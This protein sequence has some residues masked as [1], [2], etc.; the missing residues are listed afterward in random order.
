MDGLSDERLDEVVAYRTVAGVPQESAI[1]EMLRHVVNHGTYHRGQLATMLRQL[2][3][4]P[5]S[6][7][8]ILFY[9]TVEPPLLT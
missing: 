9:R 7:D 3:V 5:P 4:A 1:W 2:G 6:T 8:L